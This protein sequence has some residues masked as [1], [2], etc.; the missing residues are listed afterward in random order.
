MKAIISALS[1]QAPTMNE[2]NVYL[3]LYYFV[4]DCDRNPNFGFCNRF[5]CGIY[6]LFFSNQS[7]IDQNSYSVYQFDLIG[8][9]ISRYGR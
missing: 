6:A 8:N 5:Y 1:S 3:E 2:I 7:R 9:L 4:M